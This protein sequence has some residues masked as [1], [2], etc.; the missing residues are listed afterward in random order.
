MITRIFSRSSLHEHAD[1]AQ[2]VQG[3]AALPADSGEIAQ[4]MTSDPA[5]EVRLAAAQRCS[6]HE[7]LAGALASETEPAVRAALTASLGAALAASPDDAAVTACLAAESCP[8][9]VRI[10]VARKAE[11]GERRRAALAHV[12]DEGLLVDLALTGD[13]AETRQEAAERVHSPEALRKLSHGGEEQ[14]SWRRASRAPAHRRNDRA[15]RPGRIGRRDAD[16][17]RSAGRETGSDRQRDGRAR[18]A[19]GGAC[20]HGRR[21]PPRA[22]GSGARGSAGAL[23]PRAGRAA[24]ACAVRAPAARMAGRAAVASR[25]HDRCAARG[26]GRIARG[27]ARVPSRRGRF[28]A[29]G[30]RTPHRDLGARTRGAGRGR[31]AGCRS[32]EARR[33]NV[34]RPRG[35]PGALGGARPE[36]AWPGADAALRGRAD[37]D[38]AAP[39]R[40]D[41]C[42]AAGGERRAPA[43][44]RV[45]ARRRAGARRRPAAG[46]A[47]RRG[48]DPD[49]Q[50]GRGHA[51]EADG[52]APRAAS[53]SN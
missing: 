10:E 31:S 18:P 19:L 1:P 53:C 36:H 15:R 12:R 35:P 40:A 33:G 41:S 21:R 47:R 6:A 48:R 51:A 38:R 37:R 39:A 43:R 13:I 50:D 8:D 32:G 2:R 17:A 20:R 26:S 45:A 4:L 22:L 29:G 3:V 14:G 49:R 34:D 30:R 44:A 46:G 16:G 25:R 9:A 5:P 23:R 11:G 28:D 7:A 52:A 27:R 42:D 24:R